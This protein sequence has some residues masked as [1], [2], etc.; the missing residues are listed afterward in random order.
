MRWK[1]VPQ[2]R[3]RSC[4]SKTRSKRRV[5][6]KGEKRGRPSTNDV[7]GMKEESGG[8]KVDQF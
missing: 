2:N 8:K 6:R 1:I 4:Y 3:S 5:K 7:K